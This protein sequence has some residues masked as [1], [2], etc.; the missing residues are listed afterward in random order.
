[1][2]SI[3]P[4]ADRLELATL[5]ERLGESFEALRVE[6]LARLGRVA[7]DA[8]DGDLGDVLAADDSD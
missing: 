7:V 8:L 4:H 5:A 2:V 6:L 3:P 1:V